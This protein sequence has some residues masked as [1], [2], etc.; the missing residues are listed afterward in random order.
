MNIWTITLLSALFIYVGIA[1]FFYFYQSSFLFHPRQTAIDYQYDF[2]YPFKELFFDTPNKGKIH[3]LKFEVENS[4]GLVYYLHGNAGSLRDWGWVY[5]DFIAHGYDVLLID[6]RTYGKSTGELSENFMNKDVLYVYE[7]MKKDY[8]EDAIVIYGRSIGTG[9]ATNLASKVDAKALVLESPYY[10]I[11]D[12]AKKIAPFFPLDL[13][14]RFKFESFKSIN[15]VKSP[16]FII[17]GKNDNV[18]PFASG[19]KLYETAKDKIKFYAVEQGQHNDLQK[20]SEFEEL[21]QEVLQ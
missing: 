1:V 18:V 2:S 9:M 10:S 13:M 12:I 3:G 11:A 21:L 7:Q 6:Y 15:Q 20:F 4:K 14:L 5:P 16:I 8:A 17:H 19:W